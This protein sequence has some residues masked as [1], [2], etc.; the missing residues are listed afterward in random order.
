[1]RLVIDCNVLVSAALTDGTCRAAIVLAVERHDIYLSPSVLAEYRDVLM[2]PRYRKYQ[3]AAASIIATLE[4][5][6]RHVEPLQP[7][8]ALPDPKDSVYLATALAANAEA[9]ITGNTKDFPPH[10]CEPV[11]VLTPRA[12]LDLLCL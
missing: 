9:I 1:M 6:A 11:R 2:R 10:L 5:V 8:P 12:F 7:A 3:A 4:S